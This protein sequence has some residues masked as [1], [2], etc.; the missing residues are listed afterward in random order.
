MGNLRLKSIRLH[1]ELL[2]YRTEGYCY[3]HLVFR[4]HIFAFKDTSTYWFSCCLWEQVFYRSPWNSG[5]AAGILLFLKKKKK[6]EKK[7]RILF[8]IYNVYCLWPHFILAK[9]RELQTSFATGCFPTQAGKMLGHAGLTS[10]KCSGL[11]TFLQLLAPTE[12]WP[13]GLQPFC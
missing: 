3:G 7:G 1:P 12:C 5:S 2:S 11:G 10:S 8:L 9:S 6:N 13:S 4:G